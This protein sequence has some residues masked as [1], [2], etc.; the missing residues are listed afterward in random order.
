MNVSDA[1]LKRKSTRAFLKKEVSSETLSDIFDVARFSPSGVNTQ[2]WQVA[3]VTGDKK[4]SLCSKMEE[5]F[6]TSGKG[7]LSQ[8]N[9]LSIK[10][11]KEYFI[12]M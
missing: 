5:Q 8:L 9:S 6:R 1:L 7:N 2:P 10:A 3:V 11:P 12:T 4:Q